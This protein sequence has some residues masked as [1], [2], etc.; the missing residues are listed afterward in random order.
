MKIIQNLA[1]KQ[2]RQYAKLKKSAIKEF[3]KIMFPTSI[4]KLHE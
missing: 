1:R 2:I 3:F 4:C